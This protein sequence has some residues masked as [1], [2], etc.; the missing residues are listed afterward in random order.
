MFSN[1][2]GASFPEIDF[3]DQQKLGH[4]FL[5]PDCYIENKALRCSAC[6]G[7]L[8]WKQV[9]CTNGIQLQPRCLSGRTSACPY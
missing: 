6:G 1:Y 3:F 7:P 8:G 5:I 4:T 2:N 9:E